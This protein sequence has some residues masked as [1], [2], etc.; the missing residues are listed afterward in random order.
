[1]HS[2]GK[3]NRDVGRLVLSKDAG[4]DSKEQLLTVLGKL[5]V[6]RNRGGDRQ[7]VLVAKY[8]SAASICST[9]NK[10]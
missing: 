9:T 5:K 10:E 8:S 3:R 6:L 1:V 4:L 7:A 2:I